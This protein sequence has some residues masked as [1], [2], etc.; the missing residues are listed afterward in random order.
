VPVNNGI[1]VRRA[2][3]EGGA[4]RRK[5]EELFNRTPAEHVRAHAR[6]LTCAQAHT[7]ERQAGSEM[8]LETRR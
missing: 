6:T 8:Q 2:A 7:G 3:A 5:P 4:D 1:T